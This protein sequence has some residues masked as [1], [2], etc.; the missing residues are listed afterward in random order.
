MSLARIVF[1]QKKLREKFG[2]EGYVAGLYVEAGYSV[3]VGFETSEGRV[4]IRAEK[5]GTIY[6]IDVLTES[7]VYGPEVVEAI[8][9]K[10]KSI[11]AKP[12][13]VLYGSGPKLSKEAME[14]AKELG[15]K[16]RRVR[17]E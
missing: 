16:V 3:K 5:E 11:N 13:L 6:A 8:A 10:A 15:V 14:K 4:S 17:P 9:K 2:P 7:K 12:V 1:M